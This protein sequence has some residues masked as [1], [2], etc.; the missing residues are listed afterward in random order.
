MG[1]QSKVLQQQGV[2]CALEADVKLADL[3]FR[4]GNDGDTREAQMLEQRGDIRLIA[5]D[6]I[7]RLGQHDIKHTA[8]RILQ[9][10]LNAR[11]ENHAGTRDGG[12]VIGTRDLPLLTSGV[13]AAKAELVLDRAFALIIGGIAGIE[14]HAT[15]GWT[16]F[17]LFFAGPIILH[18]LGLIVV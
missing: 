11:A 3:A 12:I 10:R 15:H 13:L 7:Q 17:G 6:P 8:L 5:G 4:E 1:L 18:D 16:P 9:Q 2:H 14:R